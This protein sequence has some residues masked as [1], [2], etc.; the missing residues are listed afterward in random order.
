MSSTGRYRLDGLNG[1]HEQFQVSAGAGATH[2]A[3]CTAEF[4]SLQLTRASNR[5]AAG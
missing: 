4:V 1:L 2:A 3:C 5:I